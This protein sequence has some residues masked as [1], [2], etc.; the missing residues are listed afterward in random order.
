MRRTLL[1][2]ISAVLALA[3]LPAVASAKKDPPGDSA[4]GQGTIGTG[5][6]E[7]TF[8][9]DAFSDPLGQ[10]A[11]G[12]AELF[13]TATQVSNIR[14]PVNCLEV[15]G[16]TAIIGGKLDE[17]R[18]I[19]GLL[20]TQY[21]FQ[22][23]DGDSATPGPDLIGFAT[24]HSGF[25]GVEHYCLANILAATTPITSGEITVHDAVC[26]KKLDV[27][28]DGEIKCKESKEG[29]APLPTGASVATADE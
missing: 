25:E 6:L 10:N 28:K 13:S 11:H 23:V 16:K 12:H 29:P 22:V 17:P 8:D 21:S 19:G 14:G 5:A 4:V 15:T 1:T 24:V 7:R 18:E 2:L 20:F 9:F 3:V 27:K 26:D